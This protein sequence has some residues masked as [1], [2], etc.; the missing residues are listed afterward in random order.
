MK[1]MRSRVAAA[2]LPASA[3]PSRLSV[4]TAALLV[5]LTSCT[6]GVDLGHSAELADGVLPFAGPRSTCLLNPSGRLQCLGA[7]GAGQLGRA[8]GSLASSCDGEPCEAFPTTFALGDTTSVA[9]GDAFTCVVLEQRVWCVGSNTYGA[10]GRGTRDPD[11]HA[12]PLQADVEGDV[13]DARDLAL[14]PR[15]GAVAFARHGSAW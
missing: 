8:P 1:R 14:V 6:M 15:G 2:V 11:V 7:G 9:L 12:E 3:R 4:A 5:S 13:A 10:L